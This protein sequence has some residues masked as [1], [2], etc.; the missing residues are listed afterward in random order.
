[1]MPSSFDLIIPAPNDDDRVIPQALD[2]VDGFLP[3]VFLKSD[4]AG[5]HVSAEHEFLPNHN[6]KLIADIV[7]IVRLVVPA[8]PLAD[9][10]HVRVAG[11][12]QNVAMNLRSHTVGKT[13][14]RNDVRAFGEYRN[15]IHD[16]FKALSPLIGNAAQFYRTQPGFR[17]GV[18]CGVTADT[19]RSRKPV[20]V[21]RSVS[22]GIPELRCSNAQRER[23]VIDAGIELQRLSSV[24]GLRPRHF[25]VRECQS[26]ACRLTRVDIEL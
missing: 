25:I 22:H 6:A 9:H 16:E 21:L 3:D 20:A 11:G 7:E 26:G 14:E 5:N 23:N 12:L 4:V 19:D 10:I 15:S 24:G 17:L 8:A 13:V 18:S 1:M 2:L